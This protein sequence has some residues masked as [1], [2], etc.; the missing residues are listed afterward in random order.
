MALLKAFASDRPRLT[1]TELAQS[2]KLDNGAARRLLHTLA[3]W[4]RVQSEEATQHYRLDASLGSG[5]IT[6]DPDAG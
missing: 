1:L 3:V 4:G 5:L 6:A 2:S